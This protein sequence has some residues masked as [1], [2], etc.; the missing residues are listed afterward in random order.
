M[1]ILSIRNSAVTE[2]PTLGVGWS[3]GGL[4]FVSHRDY[5]VVGDGVYEKKSVASPSR[6]VNLQPGLTQYYTTKIRGSALNSVIAVGVYGNV[7]SFN[8]ATWRNHQSETYLSD[9]GFTSIAIKGQLAVA[10]G[11]NG[12]QAIAV[13]GYH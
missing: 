9:G 10:V 7:L 13:R 11:L 1:K 3:L 5:V 8:G 12:R 2:V 4:W 6:W